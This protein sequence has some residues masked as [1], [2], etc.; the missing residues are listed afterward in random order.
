[1]AYAGSVR[2]VFWLLVWALAPALSAGRAFEQRTAKTERSARREPVN[3]ARKSA[4]G[5]SDEVVATGGVRVSGRVV[6]SYGAPIDNAEIWLENMGERAASGP[7]WLGTDASGRFTAPEV[8][9][10]LYAITAVARGFSPRAIALELDADADE[11]RL[12][13]DRAPS[14]RVWV[15]DADGHPVAGAIVIACPQQ[16]DWTLVSAAD[17]TVEFGPGALGCTATA[18][19]VRHAHSRAVRL[20]AEGRATLRLEPGG[21]IEGIVTDS[22][23]R[24]LFDAKVSVT[25]FEP[26]ED[27]QPLLGSM[28]EMRVFVGRDFRLGGLAP[29]TYSV[30]VSPRA[31]GE[32]G[33]DETVLATASFEVTAGQAVRG[34]HIVVDTAGLSVAEAER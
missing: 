19:H 4:A 18:H 8:R 31:R 29:G 6:D 26:N 14:P 2:R 5:A 17:G 32:E 34:V 21:A 12:A 1:M 24:A 23:G 13:L 20:T 15:V 16:E 28:A 27:E 9:T 22:S 25:G 3:F 7:M 11:L 10:G 33:E 30:Q